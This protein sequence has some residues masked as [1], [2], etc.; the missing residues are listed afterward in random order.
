MSLIQ[1]IINDIYKALPGEAQKRVDHYV[2]RATKV[3]I[4]SCFVYAAVLGIGLALMLWIGG[5]Y[6]IGG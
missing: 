2:P 1:D 6:E 3:F 5:N 4:V